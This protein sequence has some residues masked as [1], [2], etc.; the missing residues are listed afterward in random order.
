MAE[1]IAFSGSRGW[2]EDN[3]DGRDHPF[4]SMAEP[5]YRTSTNLRE[6]ENKQYWLSEVYHQGNL[7]SCVANATAAAYYFKLKKELAAKK[8][9][10]ELFLPSRLFIY[11]IARN[12][13]KRNG[14]IKDSGCMTRNAM[15]SLE[16]LGLCAEEKW[17]YLEPAV[18]E[19]PREAAYKE[20]EKHKILKYERLDIQRRPEDEARMTD[21]EK[22]KDG[23]HVLDVLRQCLLESHPV[24]IGFL[25]Y[26]PAPAW[27]KVEPEG[28]SK[29]PAL[30][31]PKHSK[32]PRDENGNSY[33]GHAVVAVG[34]DDERQLVRCLDSWGDEYGEFWMPY[35][36]VTDFKATNDFWML[37]LVRA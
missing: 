27:T 31:T 14:P 12:A 15:R 18:N 13:P 29:L 21:V 11:W 2:I 17:P 10:R 9:D 20:A 36:W 33:G 26:W 6:G 25:Y 32:P 24:V 22:D 5:P 3:W 7:S 35:Q 16:K 23:K 1:V 19:N 28:L 30:T 8:L 34:Y 37:R 4:T